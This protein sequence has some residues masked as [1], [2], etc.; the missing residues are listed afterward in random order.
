L[1]AEHILAHSCHESYLATGASGK[2]VETAS[3]DGVIGAMAL[4]RLLNSAGPTGGELKLPGRDEPKSVALI[5]CADGAGA[6]PTAGCDGICCMTFAK[7]AHQIH[8]KLPDCEIKRFV[9]ERCAGGKGFRQFAAAAESE[10]GVQS[11]TLGPGDRVEGLNSNGDRVEIAFTRNGAKEAVTVDMAVI[12]PPMEGADGV[13]D[14]ASLMRVELD[15]SGFVKEEHERLLPFRSRL[16]GIYV[17]GCA[18]GPG[19]IQDAAAQGAAAAGAVLATLVE[20][21]K[22]TVEPTTA[23]VDADLC[24]GCHTCVLTCPYQAVTFDREKRAAEVNKLLCRGCGS[25]AAACPAGAIA[26]C[27][28]TDRQ[29]EAEFLSYLV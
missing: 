19:D 16:E 22:L 11:V 5:H 29:L 18:R 14:L 7:Y 12:A 1:V 28:F 21:R 13:A 2:A 9:W 27:H 8:E 15:G 17:A 10:S 4:E 6:A 3:G 26:H 20:G 23:E 24:G 25:C